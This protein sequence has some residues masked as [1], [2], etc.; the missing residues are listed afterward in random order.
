MKRMTL[1]LMLFAAP[2]QADTALDSFKSM[3]L[4]QQQTYL[5]GYVTALNDN[6][7]MKDIRHATRP[8]WACTDFQV[9]EVAQLMRMK[10]RRAE[11][12]PFV[13]ARVEAFMKV[14]GDLP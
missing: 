8:E 11:N 6:A 2:A 1:A 10:I 3:T 4:A 5:L 12:V 14:C 13:Q 9:I 7:T